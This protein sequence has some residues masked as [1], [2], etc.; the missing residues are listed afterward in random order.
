[1]LIRP[2]WFMVVALMGVACGEVSRAK[3]DE[4][5]PCPM[6]VCSSNGYC[7]VADNGG[8]DG[9]GGVTDSG[10]G[11]GCGGVICD[12]G[13]TCITNTCQPKYLAP[14]WNVPSE[15]QVLRSPI[16]FQVTVPTAKAADLKQ[17]VVAHVAPANGDGGVDIIMSLVDAGVYSR[18]PM[19]LSDGEWTAKVRVEGTN[20][21]TPVSF[22]VDTVPPVLS[23]VIPSAHYVNDGGPLNEADPNFANAWKRDDRVVLKVSGNEPLNSLVVSLAGITQPDAGA[24]SLTTFSPVSC[25][26]H[27]V[28]ACEAPSCFCSEVDLSV[29]VMDAFNGEFTVF[30]DATDKAGNQTAI[31]AGAVRVT[32]LRWIRAEINDW[33]VGTPA[34]GP[35]GNIYMHAFYGHSG[36][37]WAVD[38]SGALKWQ[39][40]QLG[41]TYA[42]PI[43]VRGPDGADLIF[44]ASGDTSIEARLGALQ[45]T[46]GGQYGP[47]PAYCDN[48]ALRGIPPSP[49]LVVS[50]AGL[51]A[52]TVLAGSL[53]AYVVEATG[54]ARFVLSSTAVPLSGASRDNLTNTIAI[55]NQVVYGDN[56]GS[57]ISHT[58]S[59]LASWTFGGMTQIAGNGTMHGLASHQ[60]THGIKVVGAM[61]AA[62]FGRLFQVGINAGSSDWTFPSTASMSAE[63]WT[64]A[65]KDA[66]AIYFGM[67]PIAGVPFQALRKATQTEIEPMFSAV[68]SP[69]KTS[70]VLGDDNRIY[71]VSAEGAVRAH[72]SENLSAIWSVTLG[73]GVQASPTLDCNR[74]RPG[75]P[76]VMYV[77]TLGGK[78]HAILVDA[79]KLSPFAPW[80]KYQHDSANSGN[81]D[82]PLNAGC[83]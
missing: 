54:P 2:K 29:P 45:G 22:V 34:I 57:L 1:M 62:G 10:T 6:G 82:W 40:A 24:V 15:K 20:L 16:T 30:L 63:M 59:G 47:G 48:N 42:S 76:G 38:H 67:E 37:M 69:L 8:A 66:N 61:G 31:D 44:Y 23:V 43:A 74:R 58:L 79:K 78:L 17:G 7:I 35:T 26:M 19:A 36:Q 50:D 39:N 56:T 73:Q 70:P 68:G 60:T 49:A 55:R 53:C 41:R 80:P 28:S 71:T 32:R 65:I 21:S 51:A 3:C 52:V 46:D 12:G 4:S 77:V 83:P 33:V 13:S 72:S 81:P 5:R 11:G 27:G 14:I 18:S 64:P 9:D 25:A 75:G